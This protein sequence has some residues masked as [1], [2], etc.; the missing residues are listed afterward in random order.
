MIFVDSSVWIDLFNKVENTQTS[1]LRRLRSLDGVVVGDIV[2]FEVLRG[3]SS[4]A[5]AERLV[6][7][8]LLFVQ[9][10]MLDMEIA[11][12]A[13]ENYRRLRRLGITVRK[14]PDII[15]GTYCIENNHQLLHRDRDFQPMVEHL[16]LRE[17]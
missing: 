1:K 9:E 10:S 11:R 8:L 16:G 15:I 13:A 2:L 17:F 3:A 14:F 12:K 7:E 6:R 4:D 5:H